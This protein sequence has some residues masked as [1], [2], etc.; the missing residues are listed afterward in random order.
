MFCG[1]KINEV[2]K[3]ANGKQKKSDMNSNEKNIRTHKRK[4][5]MSKKKKIILLVIVNVFV[6]LIL[7][8]F[9][10]YEYLLGGLN[11]DEIT[12]DFSELGI[13]SSTNEQITGT[14]IEN[15]ALFGVDSRKDT[16][17]GLSDS[18]I[19][20]SINR[21]T[22][23]VKLTS[24]ARDTQVEIDGHGTQKINAAYS[25]GGP[26][27]AIKTLNQNFNM[28]IKDYVT[29]NMRELIKAI[30]AVGGVT[31][32]ITETERIAANNLMVEMSNNEPR[33][34]KSGTVTLT[35]AQATAY[36]R[37]RKIDSD[38]IRTDRQRKVLE[39]LFN[40]AKTLSL[41]KLL[42]TVHIITPMV[43]TSLDNDEI[44]SL[45]K[46]L[47]IDGAKMESL[48]FPHD[49]TNYKSENYNIV[50]DLKQAADELHKFVFDDIRPDLKQ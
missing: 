36:C 17:T 23:V 48:R 32:E 11:R 47:T 6:I 14:G 24:F 38:F 44:I 5:K 39:S 22:G 1:E 3:M 49:N 2:L 10:L 8:G 45:S 46:V 25:Y 15:I 13:D 4:K 28:N 50:Y 20:A 21:K 9:L 30:D 27:L 40:K 29:I 33:I 35:G 7:L 37:I 43:K 26:E 16:F 42:E 31:I 12:Q 19:I 18:I 34:K 41:P